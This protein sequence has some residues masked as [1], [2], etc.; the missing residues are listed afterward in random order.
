MNVVG[1]YLKDLEPFNCFAKHMASSYKLTISPDRC[2]PEGFFAS[3]Q[4]ILHSSNRFPK[5]LEPFFRFEN[6]LVTFVDREDHS[7]H[8]A[9]GCKDIRDCDPAHIAVP[10][11]LGSLT[12]V[13]LWAENCL[14]ERWGEICLL[15]SAL[16]I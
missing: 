6:G 16:E 1:G 10:G 3:R 15:K 12:R 4:G 14:R 8:R 7:L 11:G 5:V 9:Y 2:L 13:W